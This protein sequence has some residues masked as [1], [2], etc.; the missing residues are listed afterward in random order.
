MPAENE[1][2]PNQTP[3]A[4]PP[5]SE[6]PQTPSGTVSADDIVSRAASGIDSKRAAPD[7]AVHMDLGSDLDPAHRALADALRL[8]FRILKGVM[9]LLVIGFLLTGI[10]S[11]KERIGI[12]YSWVIISHDKKVRKEALG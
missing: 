8:S 4:N 11:V 2:N 12:S 9:A 7:E 5:A 1:D 3:D 10:R 6:A